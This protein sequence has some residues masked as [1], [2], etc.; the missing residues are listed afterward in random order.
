MSG[1]T[2]T[3]SRGSLA[4]DSRSSGVLSFGILRDI[5]EPSEDGCQVGYC[6]PVVSPS[7]RCPE[8]REYLVNGFCSSPWEMR[9][10]APFGLSEHLRRHVAPSRA[11]FL[12]REAWGKDSELFGS[13]IVASRNETAGSLL[14][15][16]GRDC[17]G[18]VRSRYLDGHG[19]SLASVNEPSPPPEGWRSDPTKKHH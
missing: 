13:V 3:S 1:V 2:V 14:G 17:G 18:V 12:F 16:P 7:S 6:D 5:G 9:P 8:Q 15:G 4:P 10:G 11:V 19:R